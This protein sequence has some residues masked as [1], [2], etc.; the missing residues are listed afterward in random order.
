M[1]VKKNDES[2]QVCIDYRKLNRVTIK[3]EYLL[4]RRSTTCSINSREFRYSR[5]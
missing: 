2:M 4:P 5:R 3:N 1:F